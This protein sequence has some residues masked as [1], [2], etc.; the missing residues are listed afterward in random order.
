MLN[1][2]GPSGKDRMYEQRSLVESDLDHV[3]WDERFDGP[4]RDSLC[5]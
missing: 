3:L 2:W 4:P 1:A 5:G